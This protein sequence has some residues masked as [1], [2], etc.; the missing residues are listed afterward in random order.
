[1]IES[2]KRLFVLLGVAS[3]L[4]LVALVL[5]KVLFSGGGDDDTAFSAPAVAAAAAAA[6]AAPGTAAATETTAPVE[7]FEVFTTKNPFTP[8]VATEAPVADAPVTGELAPLPTVGEPG[9][10]PVVPVAPVPAPAPLPVPA[11]VVAPAPAPA[12]APTP[13]TVPAPAP[14]P[15]QRVAVLDVFFG[16]RGEARVSVR[17]NDTV[18]DVAE[19]ERFATSYQVVEL[20]VDG[21][22]AQFLFGDDRFRVCE[23]EELL[24]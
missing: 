9:A 16:A 10:L 6:P 24:K 2:N 5:P 8:L 12:P 4:L 11:P 22:C 13:T 23:G 1:M 14:R 3:V 15:L 18:Y 21:R 19:G 17:V 20:S 7:T